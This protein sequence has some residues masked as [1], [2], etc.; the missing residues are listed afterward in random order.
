[1]GFNRLNQ[2]LWLSLKDINL[3]FRTKLKHLEL[4]TV[5]TENK[6]NLNNMN[7]NTTFKIVEIKQTSTIC[8]KTK[9]L[10]NINKLKVKVRL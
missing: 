8:T 1:M 7:Q 10:N 5:Y 6:S 2:S 3:E 9:I 4:Y